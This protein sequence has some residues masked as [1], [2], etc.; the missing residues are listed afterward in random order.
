MILAAVFTAI[1]CANYTKPTERMAAGP[2]GS[3]VETTPYAT[4]AANFVYKLAADGKLRKSDK[5]V[6]PTAVPEG[7]QAPNWTG[8][9][10]FDRGYKHQVGVFNIAGVQPDAN[11]TAFWIRQRFFSNFYTAMTLENQCAI[12]STLFALRDST[13]QS[14]CEVYIYSNEVYIT[15]FNAD[16]SAP[17]AK[18]VTT[19][20]G[21]DSVT[22]YMDLDFRIKLDS[23]AGFVQVYNSTGVLIGEYLGATVADARQ[24]QDVV[25]G[26]ACGSSACYGYWNPMFTIVATTP[27][28]SMVVAPLIPKAAGSKQEQDSG[29]YSAI[30]KFYLGPEGLP[31]AA[32]MPVTL[33]AAEKSVTLKTP[34]AA[35]IGVPANYVVEA[36]GVAGVYSATSSK[37]D[38]IQIKQS[39]MFAGDSTVYSK[40][41]DIPI[42]PNY[43]RRTQFQGAVS[44]FNLN[45]KTSAAWTMA[46]VDSMEIGFTVPAV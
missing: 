33:G 12:T 20:C 37:G 6:A 14:L 45:P 23:V 3:T 31:A 27:T 21:Y 8:L 24:V 32:P 42:Y 11:N 22:R 30:S 2:A 40:Q 16:K 10:Y 1:N 5:T 4:P 35:D 41:T 36:V 28:F 17:A 15:L 46:D 26:N 13:G 34:T 7:S 29:L 25:L 38:G 9:P 19:N 44:L 18:L 43:N 39:L